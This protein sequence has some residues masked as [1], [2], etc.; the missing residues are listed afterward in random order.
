MSDLLEIG[1]T[2]NEFQ[3]R[4][5]TWY[6]ANGRKALPWQY[7]K[8][9]YRVW[10]SEIMLQQTQVATVIPYY[11]R[12]ME[13]F[14]DVASLAAASQDEV[15][16][17]WTG[18]G[19]YAR[20]R[21]LHKAAC[22]VMEAYGGEFPVHS[23]EEMASLP[24]VGRSTAGA[25]ISLSTGRRAVILDGN[26]KRVLTRLHAIEGW[27]GRTSVERI[28]WQLADRY[29]PNTD[30]PEYSQAMMD[31]GAMVCTR[32]KP[33]CLLCPFEDVCVAHA[34]GEERRFPE[35]KPK[36]RLPERQTLMLLLYD[37]AGCVYLEQRPGAGIWGGLW[38]FPQF[39]DMTSLEDWLATYSPGASVEDIWSVF[40][41]TFSH[42]RLF[43][44]PVPVHSPHGV[45]VS[46]CGGCWY[47]PVSPPNLGLAAPVKALLETLTS[48]AVSSPTHR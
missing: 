43:I 12:F 5:L 30:L 18:L 26:V 37:D 9:P 8:T 20:G 7:D 31:L 3:R 15:L 14:P 34:R 16:H 33:S 11:E 22:L 42:F 13:R 36:K 24:G 47:D 25:I 32:G 23:L 38:C 29:T 46:D 2:P 48:D 1:L 19:Y 45:A 40:T 35:S 39:D 27:P 21:N 41:H 6:Q 28:L 10:V 44:T 4:V 17:L